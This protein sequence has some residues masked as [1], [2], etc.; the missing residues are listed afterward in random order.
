M[1]TKKL[2]SVMAGKYFYLSDQLWCVM[3]HNITE[4]YT[5]VVQG[6]SEEIVMFHN[7]PFVKTPEFCTATK[8]NFKCDLLDSHSGFH[9][10][11]RQG[12]QWFTLD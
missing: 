7:N 8:N 9:V 6:N 11:R 12:K 1:N 2:F 4:G 3:E 5:S 10:D